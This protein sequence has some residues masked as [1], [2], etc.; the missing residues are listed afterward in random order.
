MFSFLYVLLTYTTKLYTRTE[1][2]IPTVPP[3]NQS[4]GDSGGEGE[5]MEAYDEASG[6]PYWYNKTRYIGLLM[7]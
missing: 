7:K 3:A 2:Q 5:W 4:Y 1:S 6:Y